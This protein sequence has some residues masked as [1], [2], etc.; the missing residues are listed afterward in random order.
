MSGVTGYWAHSSHDPGQAV[1]AAFT[2]SLAHR[3]PDGFGIEHFPDMRLWLGHRRLAILDLTERARQP[4]SYGEG[5]YWLTYNGEVYN[6]IE[7][8]EELRGLGHRFVTDCDSEVILAAY[9]QWGQGCQLRFNGMWAFAI[10]DAGERRLF[11]SRD[12]FGIK[13][14]HYCDHAGAFVFASELKAFLTLPWIDGAFDPEILAETL[15]NVYEQ[16]A[17]PRT[18]LPGVRRLPAGHAMVVEADGSRRTHAWWNTLDH[19]PQPRPSLDEQA[20]EFRAL[21]FDACRLRLRS[22]VP[23]AT[24]LSGGLDSGAIACTLAEFRRRG[25]VEHAPQDWQRAFVACFTGTSSDEREFAS[26]TI[27]HTGLVPHYDDIDDQRALACI[28][29]VIFDHE[30]IYWF[31]R[32]GSWS[33]YRAMQGAGIRVCLDGEGSDGILGSSP[34]Y[35]ETALVDAAA[36]FNLFRYRELQ[37]VLYGIGGG[38]FDVERASRI[39]ELLRFV[40]RALKGQGAL[41]P[42]LTVLQSARAWYRHGLDSLGLA[43]PSVQSFLRTPFPPYRIDSDPRVIDL[44]RLQAMLFM[45]FHGSTLATTVASFDRASMAHGVESRLPFFDWRVVTYGFAL[46]DRS[47]NGNGYTKLLLRLAMKNLMPDVIRLRT[48]KLGFISPM[49]TW[50]RGALK[51]WLL[52]LSASRSFIKNPFWNGPKARAMVDRAVIGQNS[53]MPVWPILNAHLL[54]QAFRAR[55]GN[56]AAES[57]I[58]AAQRPS[59]LGAA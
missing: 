32:V 35:L 48:S 41:Q 17:T 29:K 6:H 39:G 4:M 43:A 27:N 49:D 56:T 34:E 18:L 55:A 16:E 2:H 1:F 28:E 21:F 57:T 5:R 12:R 20:E 58:A 36:R 38:N 24:A 50:A 14:L 13:P 37:S 22:D 40:K 53:I 51:P 9:A 19:L 52:D 46:T 23:L 44:D 42:L 3:G 25:V 31:P 10:W 7:L 45:K 26:A 54:Q 11:L 59:C 30:C 8:R 15:T 33:L 47:K